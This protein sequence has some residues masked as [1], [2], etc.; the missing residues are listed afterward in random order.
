M[1]YLQIT[2]RCNMSCDHCMFSCTE[3][4]EDM[5]IDTVRAAGHVF[6]DRGLFIGG[7][8]PTLHPQFWEIVGVVMGINAMADTDGPPISLV[9]NG[10]VTATAL[11]LAQLARNGMVC[12]TL[13]QDRY[14][15]P[16][17]HD[18]VHAFTKPRRDRWE[19]SAGHDDYREIRTVKRI[20]RLGR[21]AINISD[22]SNEICCDC[23]PLV[24]P[25]GTVYRCCCKQEALG[26]VNTDEIRFDWDRISA[27]TI[28]CSSDPRMGRLEKIDGVWTTREWAHGELTQAGG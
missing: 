20:Q 4:G 10:S 13:S 1:V 18:V 24:A 26:N 28:G 11:R 2:T 7:G 21:A 12:A 23:D 6:E 19:S 3:V 25:D 8:E 17:H 16:I 27:E 14:H 9:T 22:C 5:T 15:E